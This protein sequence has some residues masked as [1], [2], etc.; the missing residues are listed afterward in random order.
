LSTKNQFFQF[1]IISSGQ[2]QR[3]AITGIFETIDSKRVIQ[4]PSVLLGSINK[5]LFLYSLTKSL[6]VIFQRKITYF[7]KL[8]FFTR[9]LYSHS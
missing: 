1:S 7:S 6:Q 4:N 3:V 9:L 2:P 8:Y 5:S